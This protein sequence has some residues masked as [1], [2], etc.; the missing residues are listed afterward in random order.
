M[1]ENRTKDF[2]FFLIDRGK[3]IDGLFLAT[4]FRHVLTVAPEHRVQFPQRAAPE[5]FLAHI[6]HYGSHVIQQHPVHRFLCAGCR[7]IKRVPQRLY[8]G[9]GATAFSVCSVSSGSAAVSA[10]VICSMMVSTLVREII[11]PT[12]RSVRLSSS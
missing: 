11:A 3:V 2:R 6:Q 10:R 8:R 5:Y 7:R 12:F 9:S 4:R 1:Q